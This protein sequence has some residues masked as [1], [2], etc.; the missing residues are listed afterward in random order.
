MK[1]HKSSSLTWMCMFIILAVIVVLTM[2]FFYTVD[3]DSTV[4]YVVNL[5]LLDSTLSDKDAGVS[6]TIGETKYWI[7]DEG[8]DTQSIGAQYDG[9]ITNE[10]SC[11]IADW[12]LIIG[13]AKPGIMDSS[14]NG[15]YT[16]EKSMEGNRLVV[17]PNEDTN[18]IPA[19]ESK[20]FGFV[21]TSEEV[22]KFTTV[23]FVGYRHVVAGQYKMFWGLAI[24]LGLWLMVAASIIISDFRTRHF[25]EVH[26]NDAKII[27]QTMKVFAEFIDA[28]DTYTKGHS[29]RVG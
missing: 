2:M 22:M 1:K 9:V 19:G 25:N 16:L 6:V 26:E 13:M 7:N 3:K 18:L 21:M 17:V 15:E 14:W 11:D 8:V 27:S 10:L 24:A 28:K 23:Q 20:T 29:V 12:K 4:E 5:N